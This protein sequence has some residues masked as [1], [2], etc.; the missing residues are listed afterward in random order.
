MAPPIPT[1]SAIIGVGLSHAEF[2]SGVDID[3][4]DL[5]VRFAALPGLTTIPTLSQWGLVL[6]ALAVAGLGLGCVRREY[7]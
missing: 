4:E 1:N 6:L 2:K 5:T 7:R 3:H